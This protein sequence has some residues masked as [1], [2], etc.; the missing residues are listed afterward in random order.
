MPKSSEQT[1]RASGSIK[2]RLRSIWTKKLMGRLWIRF[3]LPYLL[4]LMLTLTAGWIAYRETIDVLEREV[5]ER[6]D[7][8]LNQAQTLLETRFAEVESIVQQVADHPKIKGFQVVSE[9]FAGTNTYKVMA[10]RS[11]LDD[12]SVSNR[13]L[14]DYFVIFQNSSLV[15]SPHRVESIDAYYGDVLRYKDW[16]VEQWKQEMLKTF[17]SKDFIGMRTV[18]YR[19]TEEQMVT[20][21]RSLGYPGYYQGAVVAL[22]PHKE[23]EK[24]LHS[25]DVKQGG[26]VRIIDQQ[27]EM[28][29]SIGNGNEDS[30]N[31]LIS[32]SMSMSNS[33][34][35]TDMDGQDMLVSQITS[36]KTGW[37]YIAAQPAANV[38]KSVYAIKRT[39]FTLV[40]I[41]LAVIVLLALWL[42]HRNSRPL[43]R[44][45]SYVHTFAKPGMLLRG[46]R[47]D[48][49]AYLR[50]A[51]AEM[52][53]TTK[54]LDQKLT[55]RQEYA[56][57]AVFDKWLRGG[58]ATEQQLQ[59][60]LEHAGLE[61]NASRY[62]VA[63]LQLGW[64]GDDW[65]TSV[66]HEMELKRLVVMDEAFGMACVPCDV[67]DIE[68]DQVALLFYNTHA[69][70][71]T[72]REDEAARFKQ[73]IEHTLHE[74]CKRLKQSHVTP[75]CTIGGMVSRRLDVPRS[76]EQAQQLQSV[77]ER[78]AESAWT[79]WDEQE[80][81]REDL[82]VYS[83]DVELRLIHA[84]RGGNEEELL[85]V[86]HTTRI[87]NWEK[88]HLSCMMKQWLLMDL[89]STAM[90]LSQTV[91]AAMLVE[92]TVFQQKLMKKGTDLHKL[93]H[94]I[95]QEFVHMCRLVHE[96]KRSRN[97]TLFEDMT[98]YIHANYA[99]SSLSLTAV[100]D[101][102]H[103]SEAYVSAFFKEQ[104]GINFSDYV[105]ELRL[106]AAKTMIKQGLPV[107]A[108]AE[109]V[110]YNSL[111]SFS[112]AFK[113]KHGMSASEYRKMLSI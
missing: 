67:H 4:F 110:G 66:L 55:E 46:K 21:V 51:F 53:E 77:F 48:I 58:Y 62:A 19:Q 100:A 39:T 71:Q 60:S 109:R 36:E 17:H 78:D 52:L 50:D 75:I 8:A 86:L 23:I 68:Q 95:E 57:M 2:E 12:Y 24:I 73:E 106:E 34:Y 45:Y 35:R 54:T 70:G 44:L 81:G 56:R 29:G 83:P 31:K 64:H 18:R 40:G 11:A 16:D 59:S 102:L 61:R 113:R 104:R 41:S 84:V 22:I 42:S 99:D 32:R 103:V 47:S 97:E 38:L 111:N 82:Y 79:W 9:P 91:D 96:R 30:I 108:I 5:L 112:R 1:I 90:K 14:M 13:F 10:T 6:N 101:E 72:A 87:D 3:L 7:K 89:Y 107:T 49:F 28:I 15:I 74:L 43:E 33:H 26:T 76:L 105:E 25:I 69:E 27:G 63:L 37:T 93:F 80:S 88:Q 94:S 20:Y 92:T 98:A 85:Q 65:S